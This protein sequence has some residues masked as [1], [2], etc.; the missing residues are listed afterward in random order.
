MTRHVV[1]WIVPIVFLFSTFAGR[2]VQDPSVDV[3]GSSS[4]GIHS[5]RHS[6]ES[7]LREAG[8]PQLVERSP[9]EEYARNEAGYC[10]GFEATCNGPFLYLGWPPYV[11]FCTSG[12]GASVDF[13]CVSGNGS[14]EIDGV[15]MLTLIGSLGAWLPLPPHLGTILVTRNYSGLVACFG[16]ITWFGPPD[17]RSSRGSLMPLAADTRMTGIDADERT[18]VPEIAWRQE[19]SMSG[20]PDRGLAV[21]ETQDHGFFCVARAFDQQSD[22]YRAWLIKLRADG[23]T[24]WDTTYGGLSQDAPFLGQPVA[25]GGYVVAGSQ[26]V[27][28]VSGDDFWLLKVNSM[29]GSP[30]QRHYDFTSHDRALSVAQTSDGGF[31]LGG[32]AVPDSGEPCATIG[33][34]VKTDSQG[35]VEWA[36]SYAGGDV[37]IGK[38]VVPVEDGGYALLASTR[39]VTLGDID[40]VLIKTNASGVEQ[41][42]KTYAGPGNDIGMDMKATADGGY[43]VVGLTDSWGQGQGDVWLLR[44]DSAGDSVWT[45]TYGGEWPDWGL[46]IDQTDDNC[47]G[48]KDD[49]FVLTGLYSPSPDQNPQLLVVKLS[50]TGE[51]DWDTRIGEPDEAQT[52]QTIWQ[53]T[54]GSYVVAGNVSSPSGS[55]NVLVMRVDHEKHTYQVFPDPTHPLADFPTIQAAIDYACAGDTIILS[56]GVF[57]GAGNTGLSFGGK[58]IV[59]R[60]ASRNA[61][62]CVIDCNPDS[63]HIE[64]RRG[65]AFY[66]G[67][68]PGT[69]LED[70]T[71]RNGYSDP[72]FGPDGGGAI[73]CRSS[74]PT[75]RGCFFE[76]NTCTSTGGAVF[77]YQAHPVIEGCTIRGNRGRD[78]AALAAID[79]DAVEIVDCSITGNLATGDGGGIFLEEGTANVTNCTF[80]ANHAAGAGGAIYQLRASVTLGTSIIWGNC[81][82]AGD[83]WDC[84]ISGVMSRHCSDVR[85]PD[86]T[87]LCLQEAPGPN[88][89]VDPLFCFLPACTDAPTTAGRFSL[90]PSSICWP[91]N[92][93]CEALIGAHDLNCI[94]STVNEGGEELLT[95]F[96]VRPN[97]AKRG[98]AITFSV[99]EGS[100]PASVSLE[101]FGSD[102]R[103]IRTIFRGVVGPGTHRML[104]DGCD[105]AGQEA[106]SGMYF[107]R[108][109]TRDGYQLSRVVVIH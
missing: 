101:V 27:D 95:E 80:A 70:V 33:A 59:V 104:W 41:W 102:G 10:C 2:S 22:Q 21:R 56:D 38:T 71:V 68:G 92:N 53:N 98:A 9:E 31:V 43:I 23:V 100:T 52:G 109:K 55:E 4:P 17:L 94:E 107:C 84:E 5:T 108:L 75:I 49:G 14:A 15:Y 11:E 1:V 51:V 12:R 39:S 69:V 77:C 64:E 48:L 89:D 97:P 18:A 99:V 46:G 16:F 62:R 34:I 61:L 82:D 83:Q 88:Y 90:D 93:D 35:S 67:E 25:D 66:Q 3:A 79:C 96:G 8:H 32:F 13:H 36:R 24:E 106:G 78:G 81:A 76:S 103:R 91:E 86:R 85:E 19:I 44:L 20:G 30:W 73:C 7:A 65:F 26:Y 50:R 57:S 54:D 37:L 47:D 45:M 72:W 28:A 74:S 58:A 63:A 60:S 40:L 42:R 6:G 105:D 29:G 87:P